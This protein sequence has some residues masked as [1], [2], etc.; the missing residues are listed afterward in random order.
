M[1]AHAGCLMASLLVNKSIIYKGTAAA[2]AAAAADD[3]RLQ[4]STSQQ[5]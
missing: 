2:A 4:S 1:L 5:L 3:E